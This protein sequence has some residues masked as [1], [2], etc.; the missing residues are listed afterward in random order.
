MMARDPA[1]TRELG[2]A[3]LAQQSDVMDA[4]Q[5]E[6]QL[7]YRYGYLRSNPQIVVTNGPYIGR[8]YW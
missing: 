3:F 4:V 6:R 2:D 7:A 5:R 1:W 8:W